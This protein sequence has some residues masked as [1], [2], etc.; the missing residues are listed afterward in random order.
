MPTATPITDQTLNYTPVAVGIVLVYILA[1]WFLW[2]RKWFKGPAF[3]TSRALL[4]HHLLHL[5]LSLPLAEAREL[6]LTLFFRAKTAHSSTES[7]SK[8]TAS[9]VP[10][11]GASE[12][13]ASRD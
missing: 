2:A 6:E 8:D 11:G 3:R 12:K 13:K 9:P 1:S 10:D 7:D 5:L 4:L